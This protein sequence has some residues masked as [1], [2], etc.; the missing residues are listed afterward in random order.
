MRIFMTG[1]T[2]YVG[3]AIL[4]ALVRAGHHVD[5]LVRH[6]EKAA[7]VHARGARPV[8]GDLG[9]P[10]AYTAAAAAAYGVTHAALDDSARGAG[11]D[12]VA[13]DT[14]LAPAD[15]TGRFFIYTSGV[16]ILGSTP[17]P[18]DEGASPFPAAI[19]AW[20]APHERRVLDSKDLRTIVVRP[21]IV[22]GGS[23]GIVGDLFRDASNGL[24]RVIGSG[25]NHWALVYDRDLGDLYVRLA[26][27]ADAAGVY[28][29]NDE[30]DE[31][32][33][34]LVDAIGAHVNT[35]PGIRHVPLAEARQKMGP[36]ADALALDQVVRS[37]RA[38][39]L[40]WRPALHSVAGNAP[41]LLEEWRRGNETA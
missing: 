19:S 16:W 31:R 23:R 34:D 1:G 18:A 5:A 27:R 8:L 15:R 38:R 4:D 36:Y 41:R 2:G 17:S 14:L 12:A 25:D 29:A 9:D 7:I 11:L 40:G 10:A 26:A 24:I 35:R 28:H 32:V 30:G 13:L 22:Y 6:R 37:P 39:A 20:R 3:S 21:G 33:S